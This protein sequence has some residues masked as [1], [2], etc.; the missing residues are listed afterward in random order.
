MK[1]R[2]CNILGKK[3]AVTKQGKQSVEHKLS[4]SI[5]GYIIY[6]D[7]VTKCSTQRIQQ[8]SL[9]TVHGLGSL[10]F[11]VGAMQTFILMCDQNH[12]HARYGGGDL[13]PAQL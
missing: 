13:L 7:A 3:K 12:T 5:M 10:S 6:R 2:K 11:H 4:M 1:S 9:H 8:G